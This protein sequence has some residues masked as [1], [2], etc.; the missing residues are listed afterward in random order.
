MHPITNVVPLS[1]VLFVSLVKEA[2]EDWVSSRY[3]FLL[4]RMSFLL[5]YSRLTRARISMWQMSLCVIVL[6]FGLVFL[7]PEFC[8]L[9]VNFFFQQKRLQNDKSINNALVDVLL[10]QK[11]ERIPWKKLQVGDIVKV[12][13]FFSLLNLL[14]S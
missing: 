2:F 11:W 13:T 5:C 4:F 1:L 12:S 9:Y 7:I 8:I 3:F 14:C 6:I 10:D